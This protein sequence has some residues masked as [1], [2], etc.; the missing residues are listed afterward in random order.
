MEQRYIVRIQLVSPTQHTISIVPHR[1]QHMQRVLPWHVIPIAIHRHKRLFS[2]FHTLSGLFMVIL[3]NRGMGGL[4]TP[5]HGHLMLVHCPIVSTFTRYPNCCPW[6]SSFIVFML[7]RVCS[8]WCHAFFLVFL[9]PPLNLVV[10]SICIAGSWDRTGYT[11]WPSID[12]GTEMFNA[13]NSDTAEWTL[14]DFDVLIPWDSFVTASWHG[15]AFMVE[16]HIFNSSLQLHMITWFRA[17]IPVSDVDIR[18][19]S[20]DVRFCHKTCGFPHPFLHKVVHLLY[21]SRD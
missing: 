4:V 18:G 3:Q 19:K 14:S 21:F 15:S 9:V 5:A 1:M 11:V 20:M 16:S 2:C 12:V 13:D 7:W 10:C 6:F 17:F 8:T